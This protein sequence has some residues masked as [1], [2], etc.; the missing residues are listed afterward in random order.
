MDSTD[1]LTSKSA[2]HDL[3]AS[4]VRSVTRDFVLPLGSG[5][6]TLRPSGKL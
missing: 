6:T 2:R 3:K 4:F 5:A 1:W